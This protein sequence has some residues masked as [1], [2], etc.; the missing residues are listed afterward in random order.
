MFPSGPT[1][2][3]PTEIDGV[4]TGGEADDLSEFVGC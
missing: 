3:S 1:L 4:A 2:P